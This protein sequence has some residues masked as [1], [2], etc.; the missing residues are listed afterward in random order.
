MVLCD[1]TYLDRTVTVNVKPDHT[2][3]EVLETAASYYEVT[4]Y[5]TLALNNTL[6]L[7]PAGKPAEVLPEEMEVSELVKQLGEKPQLELIV[8]E[9]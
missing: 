3:G 2:V 5:D 1:V 9:S 4:F 7:I 8:Q 6:V